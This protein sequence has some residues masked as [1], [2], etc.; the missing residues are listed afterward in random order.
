MPFQNE[1][2]TAFYAVPQPQE[3][4]QSAAVLRSHLQRRRRKKIDL[5]LII[6]CFFAFK[7]HP[8]PPP[9]DI[10]YIFRLRVADCFAAP[11]IRSVRR[12]LRASKAAPS[13]MKMAPPRSAELGTPHQAQNDPPLT[14][15]PARFV[16]V[17][18][19]SRWA[20][21][22]SL[23]DAGTSHPHR[24]SWRCSVVVVF[25]AARRRKIKKRS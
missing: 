19:A 3:P 12:C 8:T 10:K 1:N 23:F 24:T 9:F 20:A 11:I 6:V 21:R 25:A 16:V 15:S 4:F 22:R 5:M 2:F 17:S 18:F 14:I 13:T 7:R